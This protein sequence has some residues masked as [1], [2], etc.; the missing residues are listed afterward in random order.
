MYCQSRVSPLAFQ[1]ATII[2]SSSLCHH[3]TKGRWKPHGLAVAYWNTD[4]GVDKSE[5]CFIVDF[6]ILP[7]ELARRIW[8]TM[9]T[10]VA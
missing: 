8:P 10:K 3:C 1:A 2:I 9:C 7:L 5:G 6:A 4:L